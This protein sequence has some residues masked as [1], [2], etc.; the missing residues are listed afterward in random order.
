[1]LPDQFVQCVRKLSSLHRIA[2]VL[3][4]YQTIVMIIAV[5]HFP[6]L[7]LSLPLGFQH[8]HNSRRNIDASDTA[9]RLRS[10]QDQLGRRVSRLAEPWRKD[11]DDVFSF[12]SFHSTH[13]YAQEF[14]LDPDA[15]PVFRYRFIA[16]VHTVPGKAESLADPE[17]SSKSE[18][19]RQ[20]QLFVLADLVGIHYRLRGPDFPLL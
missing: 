13:G 16:D 2:E 10:L 18:I 8:L 17:R 7:V 14:L 19:D 9:L 15:G 1:M 5:E 20:L 11:L 12:Q 6:D 3:T 4:E